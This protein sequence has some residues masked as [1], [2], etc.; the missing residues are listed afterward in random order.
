MTRQL[1][2]VNTLAAE[3]REAFTFEE[4]RAVLGVSAPA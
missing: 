1:E 2:L 3:G 4:A